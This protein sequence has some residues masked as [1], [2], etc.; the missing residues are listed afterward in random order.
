MQ[1]QMVCSWAET[2]EATTHEGAEPVAKNANCSFP[3]TIFFSLIFS[4]FHE[5]MEKMKQGVV[6]PELNNRAYSPL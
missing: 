2:I 4:L 5:V 3:S 1:E 6:K